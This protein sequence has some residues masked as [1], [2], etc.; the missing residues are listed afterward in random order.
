MERYENLVNNKFG[1]LTV[2]EKDTSRNGAR[3]WICK[4]DCG[5]IKSV[6]TSHLKSGNVTSCGCFRKEKA[7]K[8]RTKHGMTN[9]AVYRAWNSMKSRC[10]LDSKN[11][12]YYKEKGITYCKE[13]ESFDLFYEEF[14]KYYFEGAFLDR[15]DNSK[16]YDKNNCRWVTM[17]IS[18]IN[19]TNV[20]NKSK[21]DKLLK[22]LEDRRLVGSV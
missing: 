6:R 1:R 9:T 14:G 17:E 2:V 12:K 5:N 8:D 21:L 16:G 15:I 7:K 3:Y 4:C 20:K 18:N 22:E 11:S 19:K 10:N 13:W